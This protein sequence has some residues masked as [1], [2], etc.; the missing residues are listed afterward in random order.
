MWRKNFLVYLRCLTA[1]EGA[2]RARWR[3]ARVACLR[4]AG[5]SRGPFAVAVLDGVCERGKR[6]MWFL[7]MSS[8]CPYHGMPPVRLSPHRVKGRLAALLAV[9]RQSTAQSLLPLNELSHIS[10]D[11]YALP[12]TVL[13]LPRWHPPHQ[14]VNGQHWHCSWPLGGGNGLQPGSKDCR[15][16]Q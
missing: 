13:S 7:P 5:A 12:F 1:R 9:D 3:R 10:T 16:Q 4:Q 14:N 6:T 2:L 8:A 11:R 15:A